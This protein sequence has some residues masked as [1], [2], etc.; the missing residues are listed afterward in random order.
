MITRK[1]PPDFNQLVKVLNKQKAD[2]PVLF[3][4]F[5]NGDLFS[6]V[7]GQSF[8]KLTNNLDKIKLIINFFYTAGYDYATIPARYF[9]VFSFDTGDVFKKESIS[10]NEGALIKDRQSFESYNWPNLEK[11]NYK[12]LRIV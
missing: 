11:G 2:R 1:Y 7:T 5:M 3:E 4:Y 10:L 8:S 12:L 9:D 6:H